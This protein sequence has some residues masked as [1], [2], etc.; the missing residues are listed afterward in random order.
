[1]IDVEVPED[2]EPTCI[3]MYAIEAGVTCR[4]PWIRAFPDLVPLYSPFAELGDVNTCLNAFTYN[5][6]IKHKMP[7]LVWTIP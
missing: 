7:Q 1:M 4:M 6:S 3:A 2:S 5:M